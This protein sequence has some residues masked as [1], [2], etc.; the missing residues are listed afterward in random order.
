VTTGA[1]A[2][3]I[4]DPRPDE[5]SIVYVERERFE[6]MVGKAL[7]ALPPKLGEV[8][9]NVAVTVDHDGGPPGLLGLYRG[10]P[11]T[12]RTTQYSE[13]PTGGPFSV[14]RAGLTDQSTMSKPRSGVMAGSEASGRQA[15][16]LG[17]W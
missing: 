4:S 5:G 6:D 8:M 3:K 1:G 12:E 11:L 17:G 15:S 7:D 2:E 10:I 13:P 14:E 9:R 16:L